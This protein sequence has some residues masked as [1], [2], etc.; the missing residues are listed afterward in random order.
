MFRVAILIIVLSAGLPMG[1]ARCAPAE[2]GNHSRRIWEIPLGTVPEDILY[3]SQSSDGLHLA[4]AATT[5]GRAVAVIDGKAE[6]E[7]DAIAE[8]SPRF[9]PNGARVAYGAKRGDHWVVLVDGRSGPE[10]DE[11]GE[12]S[13]VFGASG[14]SV[15]YCARVGAQWTVIRS[16]VRTGRGSPMSPR[17]AGGSWW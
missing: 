12:D 8:D 2:R 5:G 4:F 17:A 3:T 11:L 16:S 14:A 9:S 15:A 1:A 13:P 7:C 6:P 10:C